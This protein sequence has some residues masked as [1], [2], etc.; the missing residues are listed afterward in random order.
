MSAAIK[1]NLC[2]LQL[3]SAL[4][5]VTNLHTPVT[6]KAPQTTETGPHYYYYLMVRNLPSHDSSVSAPWKEGINSDKM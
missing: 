4:S 1:G 2:F 5:P 3:N 6:K